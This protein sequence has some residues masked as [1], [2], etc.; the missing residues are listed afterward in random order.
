MCSRGKFVE[1]KVRNQYYLAGWEEKLTRDQ[2]AQKC[3]SMDA[4]LVTLD[5]ET[6]LAEIG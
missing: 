1:F 6:K 5:D 3:A 4:H 2:A